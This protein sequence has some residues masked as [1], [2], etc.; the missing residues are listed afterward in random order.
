[1]TLA[2]RKVPSRGIFDPA[3]RGEDDLFSAIEAV[4]RDHLELTDA[5]ASW[6]AALEA[7]ALD[8]DRRDDLERAALQVQ[9]VSDTAYFYAGLAFGLASLC[10]YRTG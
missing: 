1:M 2:L 5:R 8:L 10:V 9:T 7:A 3:A 4:A 6:R